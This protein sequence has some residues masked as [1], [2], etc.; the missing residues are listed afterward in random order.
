VLVAGLAGAVGAGGYSL[1]ALGGAGPIAGSAV[2]ATV[3]GFAGGLISRRL[4]I[5]P[6]VVA[7]SGM[8][9]LLPGLTT[10]RALFEMAVERTDTG[11]S[12]L[13]VA[14]S[15]ALALAAGV[16]LGEYLAQ[17]VR[18]GLGRL[19]RRLSGPRMAGPLRPTRRRL[20]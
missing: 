13:M 6:L 15:V 1:L 9:P 17:P 10:Y 14:T 20:E 16:A 2:A 5:P 19:E 8:V 11:L 3:I 12:T 4:R 7:V 18:Y